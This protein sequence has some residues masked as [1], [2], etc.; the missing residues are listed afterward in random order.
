L[1]PAAPSRKNAASRICGAQSSVLVRRRGLASG[2]V[3]RA[4]V[5]ITVVSFWFFVVGEGEV[6]ASSLLLD[7]SLQAHVAT[8]SG[9]ELVVVE[10]AGDLRSTSS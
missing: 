3:A 4:V 7:P 1:D 10:R 9:E 6:H 8:V 2:A 5:V